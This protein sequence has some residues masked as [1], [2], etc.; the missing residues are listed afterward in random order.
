MPSLQWGIKD[1]FRTYVIGVG[2][3]IEVAAPAAVAGAG[4][5]FPRS[6]ASA[7]GAGAG[8]VLMFCGTV[9]FTAHQGQL[10]LVV[11]DPWIHFGGRYGQ[12]SIAAGAAGQEARSRITVAD[13]DLPEATRSG[14]LLCWAGARARLAEDGA[15][16]FDFSYPAGTELSPVSFSWRASPQ[17]VSP[18]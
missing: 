5:R 9:S 4:Y 13:L 10:G 3:T 11:A 17:V 6:A 7:T 8:S 15:A 16:V 14:E 18:G 2:G 1:S 12:L